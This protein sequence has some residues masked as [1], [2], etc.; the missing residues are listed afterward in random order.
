[1]VVWSWE[2][3]PNVK[4]VEVYIGPD[5]RAIDLWGRPVPLEVVGQRT[6]LPIGP[7]PLIV[8]P[9]NTSLALLQASFQIGPTYVQVHHPE[10][11]PV[12]TFRN[13]Y[14]TYLSGEVRLTPP[15]NWQVEPTV[16]PFALGPGETFS[17]SLTLTLPPR[18]ISKAHKLDARLILH[19]PEETELD[20]PESLT[21]GL[22]DISLD[23]SARWDGNDLVVQQSLQNLSPA[24][25]SFSAFCDAAGRA[26][27]E[28]FFNH[29]GPGQVSIQTYVFP[30][31]RDLAGSKLPMGVQEIGGER[32]LNQFAEVPR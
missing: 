17:E 29:V 32:A 9:L 5:A 31:A 14:S 20:F 18:Q 22:Y 7:T 16:C 2:E 25:V 6:R 1:M 30:R 10:P 3:G 26:R 13:P 11:R 24:P 8:E 28:R 4:P 21:V 12:V 15:G 19:T 23:A 27:Q